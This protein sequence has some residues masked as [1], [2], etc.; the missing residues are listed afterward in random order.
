MKV[1]PIIPSLDPDNKLI[2]LV[3]N[4][5]KS[6]YK[7]IIIVDDGT[8]DK[9]IFNKLKE[10]KECIILTHEENKGKGEALKTAFNYYK[11][12]PENS[13]LTVEEKVKVIM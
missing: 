13:Q 11:D 10:Y 6:G 8:K 5:I 7:K 1:V 3:N 4:L 9:T 12:N 2:L